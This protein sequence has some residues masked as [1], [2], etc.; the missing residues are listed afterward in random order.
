MTM[1]ER[2]T[3]LVASPAALYIIA[4]M[5]A[6]LLAWTALD[7]WSMRWDVPLVYSGDALAVGAHFKT[8]IETGWYEW[9][10]RLGAPYGQNY[11]D[12][13]TSDNLHFAAALALSLFTHN[14]AVAMNIHFIVGFPLAA[15]TALWFLR[16]LG[17][18]PVIAVAMSVVFAIAP[19]HFARSEGHLFLAWYFVVPLAT[20][21][22]YDLATGAPLFGARAGAR[23]GLGHLTGRTGVTVAILVLLGSCS[24]YYSAFTL[25][26]GGIAAVAGFVSR[27]SWRE[28]G[29]GAVAAVVLGVV[30]VVN[31]LPDLLYRLSHGA[32]PGALVRTPVESEI[33]A[34]KLAQLLLPAPGHR[35]APFGYLRSQYDAHYPLPSE[36]P[37][38]GLV[39]AAGLVA[40]VVYALV[41]VA[42]IATRPRPQV[43][44]DTRLATLAFLVIVAFLFSTV[45]GLSTLI[46]FVSTSLRAWNRISIVIALLG[47]A[48]V[49]LLLDR[50][51][52]RMRR[53]ALIAHRPA[54]LVT[55]PLALVL[56][57]VGF[58][59][60]APAASAA[61][62]AAT[63][64]SYDSDAEFVRALEQ[65]TDSGDAIL[66][67][68]YIAFPE[69]PPVNGVLDSDQL[70]PFLHS[71][72]LRWSGGG[73]RGRESV[74]S[75][76]DLTAKDPSALI[77][78][79]TSLG[80]VGVVVD[81]HAYLDT[82]PVAEIELLSAGVTI[83]SN[84][85]RFVYVGFDR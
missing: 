74:D 79:S 5:L 26:L 64:A 71:F 47:L 46:S 3:L 11:H 35:F 66:Q 80:F 45:G 15:L 75:L 63:I 82:S 14:W 81:T 60:Q 49:A 62:R 9:Q 34:L 37:A 32:N 61:T 54:A 83:T 57:L 16:R 36:S 48:A 85:G 33:Y 68:P 76:A 78:D 41:A 7:L 77:A 6:T 44:P 67:L 4:A 20:A 8:V 69:S 1:R 10:P 58:W 23:R 73:I 84:D 39:A 29:A 38:L 50:L 12:Y 28:L 65:A 31:M 53:N 72:D 51:V 22:V 30:I 40:L 18:S 42:T 17:V 21:L 56:L 24:V 2:L 25:I 52:K 13:P 43:T 19:Y 59:D 27:R 55:L 70:R